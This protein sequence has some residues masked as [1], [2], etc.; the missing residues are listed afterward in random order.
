MLILRFIHREGAGSG[1]SGGR[2]G[3]GPGAR[4]GVIMQRSVELQLIA[5]AARIYCHLES[6][7]T[8][9]AE[10]TRNYKRPGRGRCTRK[11]GFLCVEAKVGDVQSIV[12]DC[13]QRGC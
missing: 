4:D 1:A 7:A 5:S 3:Q 6:A 13:R 8:H 2:A 9:A 12:A 11:T 10:R